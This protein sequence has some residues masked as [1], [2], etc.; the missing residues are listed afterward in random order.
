MLCMVW[1][2]TQGVKTQQ[3][4]LAGKLRNERKA[5]ITDL[6]NKTQSDL[7]RWLIENS[8]ERGEALSD[9]ITRLQNAGISSCIVHDITGHPVFPLPRTRRPSS[10][11]PMAWQQAY[12]LEMAGQLAAAARLYD[13]AQ[14]VSRTPQNRA[15]AIRGQI[16]CLLSAGQKNEA[17]K[18]LEGELRSPGIHGIRDRAGNLFEADMLLLLVRTAGWVEGEN[19]RLR[20][21]QLQKLVENRTIQM[22]SIQRV[23]LAKQLKLMDSTIDF[24]WVDFEALSL[25]LLPDQALGR[26]TELTYNP[27]LDLWFTSSPNRK[28]RFFVSTEWLT[29]WL[30]KTVEQ[31]DIPDGVATFLPPGHR[32][33]AELSLAVGGNMP[34]WRIN[35]KPDPGMTMDNL[36]TQSVLKYIATGTVVIALMLGFSLILIRTLRRRMVLTELR[37]DLLANVSHELKTP[38]TSTRAM[39]ETLLDMD[40]PNP[41]KT[42]EYLEIISRE[43]QRL[44]RLVENFLTFS[45][46]ESGKY[47]VGYSVVSASDVLADAEA[48][49]ATR[50][51]LN[52]CT[53]HVRD[54]SGDALTSVDSSLIVT[55]LLNL[56]ENAYK[57][58]ESEKWIELAAIQRDNTVCF[59]VADHGV[60]LTSQEMTKI[61]KRYYR[62]D[63]R[64]AKTSG[65]G[66]GL[67][68]VDLA[69]KVH[70]GT[71]TVESEQNKGSRFIIALPKEDV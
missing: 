69:T 25:Q 20:I 37:N 39:V 1:L 21:K 35:Y 34:G 63:Q 14:L 24:P 70:K 5:A 22:P 67:S 47:H 9:Y 66:I 15:E 64:L 58:S 41:T 44:S 3:T 38:L 68:I 40:R 33:P 45:R 11:L 13:E 53:F 62:V 8:W 29:K 50:I 55:A 36:V 65:C 54:D 27:A 57:Y 61:F 16:R 19:R 26:N 17:R 52:K 12:R 10:P 49:V 28:T 56:I 46:L 51:P 71:V 4:A 30:K 6:R 60:G 7:D 43:N 32:E 42:R 2:I 31:C 59:E 18:W 48:L 23:F